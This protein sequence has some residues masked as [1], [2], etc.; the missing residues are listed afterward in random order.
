M[1][2]I[3]KYS[4]FL[5]I[6]CACLIVGS[7]SAQRP[8]RGGGRMSPEDAAKAWNVQ[9]TSV[10]A[11]LDLTE[12][13]VLALSEAYET[14][15]RDHSTA[16]REAMRGGSSGG[17]P[18]ARYETIRDLKKTYATKLEEALADKLDESTVD[19][20]VAALVVFDRQSDVMA[21]ALSGL[22]LEESKMQEAMALVSTYATSA[23]Q[24]TEK[25]V[26]SMSMRT[27][28]DA[29]QKL[30]AEL[31]NELSNIVDE[32]Q[33]AVWKKATEFRRG[34]RGRG[35]RGGAGRGGSEQN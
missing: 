22:G 2:P 19:K 20:A 24:A 1:T 35:G 28:R 13:D 29:R 17:D 18:I 21:A 7:A 11:V 23:A 6:F 16:M 31:T 34:G 15:R 14:A 8:T 33:L 30:K 9:A 10:A 25:A 26:E 3:R 4:T 12:S 27:M 5:A 32:E